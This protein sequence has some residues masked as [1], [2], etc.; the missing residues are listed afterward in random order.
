MELLFIF[1]IVVSA[2]ALFALNTTRK[3]WNKLDAAEKDKM[4]PLLG[5]VSP[6]EDGK[7]GK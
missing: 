4:L 7:E 6:K 3:K 2:I 1:I 5:V